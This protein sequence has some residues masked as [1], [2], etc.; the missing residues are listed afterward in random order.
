MRRF[1]AADY[2]AEMIEHIERFPR[3]R[4]MPLFVGNPD[5]IVLDRFGPNLPL[6]QDWTMPALRL[7][8]ICHR[9]RSSGIWRPR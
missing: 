3:L 6:I 1:L 8:R 2:N 9:I 4:D 7:R 5:D